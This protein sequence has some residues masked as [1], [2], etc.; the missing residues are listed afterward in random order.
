M[1][2]GKRNES[3]KATNH[4]TRPTPLKDSRLS[5]VTA[6]RRMAVSTFRFLLSPVSD[7]SNRPACSHWTSK[8]L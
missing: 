3:G 6:S 5:S 4:W 8:R 7:G 2:R 1:D